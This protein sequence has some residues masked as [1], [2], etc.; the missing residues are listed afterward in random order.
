LG[1]GARDSG[2]TLMGA[3]VVGGGGIGAGDSLAIV[4][5]S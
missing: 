1:K 2:E 5:G 3:R 4:V